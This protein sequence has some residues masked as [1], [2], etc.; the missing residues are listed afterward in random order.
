MGD[1]DEGRG[2]ARPVAAGPRC[3]MLSIEIF[4][5]ASMRGD[6]RD[7]ARPVI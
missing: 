7:R 1:E 3:T 4:S 5:S 2:G 6:R